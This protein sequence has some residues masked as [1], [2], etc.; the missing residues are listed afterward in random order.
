M[1]PIKHILDLQHG[2]VC[3]FSGKGMFRAFK[4]CACLDAEG[5]LTYHVKGTPIRGEDESLGFHNAMDAS[6]IVCTGVKP[7]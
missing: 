5:Q 4:V 6:R 1:P 7:Q 3:D 2:Q